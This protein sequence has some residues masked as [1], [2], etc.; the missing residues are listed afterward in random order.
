VGGR[1][2]NDYL[3]FYFEKKFWEEIRK[4]LGR[5]WE[6]FGK[7][8]GR[9]WEEIL[10]DKINIIPTSMR[11]AGGRFSS[12][13]LTILGIGCGCGWGVLFDGIRNELECTKM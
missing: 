7:N 3:K 13:Y 11:A 2:S 4:T 5:I 1:F 10:E 8:L 6:D 12:D 9:I